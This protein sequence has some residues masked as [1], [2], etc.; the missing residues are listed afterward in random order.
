MI[1]EGFDGSSS[2]NEGVAEATSDEESVFVPSVNTL[3][4]RFKSK[5]YHY[6]AHP[7]KI[8]SVYCNTMRLRMFA[9]QVQLRLMGICCLVFRT[10]RYRLKT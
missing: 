8:T 4:V 9:L 10:D 1:L 6:T 5:P 7:G 3:K 2:A